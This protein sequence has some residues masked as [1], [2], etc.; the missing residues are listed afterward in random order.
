MWTS[1]PNGVYDSTTYDD[2]LVRISYGIS[3]LDL[4]FVSTMDDTVY[5]IGPFTVQARI[6]SRTLTSLPSTINLDVKYT[7]NGIDNYDTIPMTSLGNSIYE[8]IIPQHVFGTDITYSITLIDSLGNVCCI[9]DGF[10][11]QR[12]PTGITGYVIIGNG[13]TTNYYTPAS[14][15]YNYSWARMLYLA[16]EFNIEENGV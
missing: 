1:L 8:A 7:F 3:G 2:T 9:I 13:T 10:Y 15:Y 5:T 4:E 12:P 16:R 6:V 11:I 14:M